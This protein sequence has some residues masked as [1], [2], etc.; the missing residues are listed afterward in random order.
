[1]PVYNV[2]F[3]Q[4]GARLVLN[5]LRNTATTQPTALYLA[6]LTGTATD[7]DTGAGFTEFTG[8]TVAAAATPADDRATI[9]FGA[10][11]D[12]TTP[13]AIATA[14]RIATSNSQVFTITTAGPTVISG[15]AITTALKKSGTPV[16]LNYAAGGNVIWYGELTTGNPPTQSAT[17]VSVVATDTLTFSAGNITI[18]LY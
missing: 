9:T 2:S 7:S 5:Y 13:V 1:M 15:I 17:T 12:I 3:S 8:Y 11:A 10:A 14:Q 16:A 6:L 18:D 4:H